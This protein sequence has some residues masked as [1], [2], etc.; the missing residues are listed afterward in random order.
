MKSYDQHSVV[1]AEV[2]ERLAQLL[3]DAGAPARFGKVLEFGCGTGRLTGCLLRDFDISQIVLNDLLPD[4]APQLRALTSQH[5]ATVEFIF[6]PVEDAPLPGGLD[7]VASASTIQ[8]LPDVG[9][10]LRRLSTKLN[11]GGW[12]AI[13]GYGAAH[14]HEL[15]ALGSG[16]SAPSY[17]NAEDWPSLLPS[18]VGLVSALQKPITLQFDT[19]VELLR[20]LRQTGVNG[21]ARQHWTRSKLRAFEERYVDRFG[22]E[23]GLPLTYDAVMVVAKLN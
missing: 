9:R 16:A 12:L 3:A 10:A 19:A 8:W 4:V 5:S 1:Q 13:A 15:R 21:L 14:F 23:K 11:D 7:L 2:A 17:Y 18:G 20:H 22:S 6:G